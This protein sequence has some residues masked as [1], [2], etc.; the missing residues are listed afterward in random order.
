MARWQ[1]LTAKR[2]GL[3]ALLDV[4]ESLQG[5]ALPASEIER[6]ILPARIADYSTGDLDTVMAG[7]K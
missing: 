4:V 1:G 7:E 3:D 5:A 2:R 6:E